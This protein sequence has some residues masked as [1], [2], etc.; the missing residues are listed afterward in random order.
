MLTFYYGD[1]TPLPL[2]PGNSW[3]QIVPLDTVSKEVGEG[4]LELNPPKM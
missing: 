2:K 3:L 4:Q 1:G